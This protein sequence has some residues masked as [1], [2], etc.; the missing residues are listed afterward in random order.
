[1]MEKSLAELAAENPDLIK[2]FSYTE[3]EELKYS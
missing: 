1:M 2:D 3:K